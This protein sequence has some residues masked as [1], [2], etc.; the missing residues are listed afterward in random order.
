[1]SQDHL[2]SNSN[3]AENSDSPPET[4]G[5][6]ARLRRTPWR[7]W[8]WAVPLA[9]M[10]LVGYLVV[11]TWVFGGPVITVTFPSAEGVSPTGMAV[12]YKGVQ[13][14]IVK[15]VDL[16]D[17]GHSVLLTMGMDSSVS[18]MMREGTQFWIASPSL[19]SGNLA[20]LLSGSYVRMRP[21]AKYGNSKPKYHFTGLLSPPPVAPGYPGEHVTV[22]AQKSGS[23]SRGTSVLYRGVDAGQVVDVSYDSKLGRVKLNVYVRKSFAQYITGQTRFWRAGGVGLSTQGGVQVQLPTISE[24]LKGAISFDVLSSAGNTDQYSLYDSKQQA[25]HVLSGPYAEFA[26]K[27]YQP[28]GSLKAGS[29]VML[30]GRRVGKVV[31]VSFVYDSAEHKMATPAVI[32]L[33]ADNFGLKS[34]AD[35]SKGNSAGEKSK[36]HLRKAVAGMVKSGMRGQLE[37]SSLILGSKQITLVM[38]GQTGKQT[39]DLSAKLPQ[40]PV[41]TG[42]NI[43]SIIASVGQITSKIN[44]IPIAQISQRITNISGEVDELSTRINKLIASPQVTNSLNHLEKSLA[45]VQK[46]TANVQGQIAPTVKS[47]RETASSI[48]ALTQTIKKVMVGSNDSQQSIESLLAELDRAARAVRTLANFINRHPEALIRG[49]SQ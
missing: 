16:I 28:A 7:G 48:T 46:I 35:S 43:Q 41:A 23:V 45:N 49:R 1:M 36:D 14:G 40:I 38:S 32:A 29:S 18:N 13:V 9:A 19:L 17:H 42:G 44:R 22:Y 26:L 37:S 2:Q 10:I 39:L 3:A 47:L 8:I 34:S 30:G 21:A 33:Y 24:L 5:V 15:S 31:Q 20:G 25:A 11:R 12:E 4:G 27:F 6:T